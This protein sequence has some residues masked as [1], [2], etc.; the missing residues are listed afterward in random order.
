MTAGTA[1]RR[2]NMTTWAVVGV[3][4]AALAGGLWYV[5]AMRGGGSGSATGEI[6][7]VVKQDFEITTTASGELEARN[8]VELRSGL[9][10]QSLITFIVP[11][12]TRVKAGD[13]VVQLQTD[14][15][16]TELDEV[17]AQV[18]SA[19]AQLV[20]ANKA[21]EIQQNENESKL[22]QAKLAVTIAELTLA[23]WFEGD[24]AIKRR[25][26]S[27]A[28]ERAEVELERLADR[29]GKSQ[30]L[31]ERE[32]V[33]K[34]EM[35]RDEV[36]YIEAISQWKVS[37][38]ERVVYETYQYPKDEKQKRSDVTEAQAEVERVLLNNSSELERKAADRANAEQTLALRESRQARLK[39]Q[40][41]SATIVAPQDGLVVYATSLERGGWGG[42]GDVTLQIGQQVSPNQ[43]MV[44][45]PD[46]SEMLA[47]VRVPEALAGRVRKGMPANVRVDAAGGLMFSGEVESIGVIAETGGWRDPNLREYTVRISLDIGANAE[48]LKPSMRAE[49]KVTLGQAKDA[50]TV[51]IQAVF[52]DGAVQYVNRVAA[53]G[54]AERVPIKLGKRSDSRAEILAGVAVGEHVLLRDPKPTEVAFKGWDTAQLTSMGYV[55]D[56]TGQP[57]A[58]GGSG[59]GGPG[60]PGG[61]GM[62]RGERPAGGGEGVPG[63]GPGAAPGGAPRERPQRDG[64]GSGRAPRPVGEGETKPTTPPAVQPTK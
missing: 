51:P 58:P 26:L 41:A 39:H 37:Q 38:L 29:Y 6:A 47:A 8:R 45:L 35:D 19:R 20:S 62:P 22:R 12:G 18:V 5:V 40:F 61:G 1:I 59:P 50:L 31:Y 27:L 13:L 24:V 64:N 10:R 23:Q 52:Q 60:G 14:Q 33:S 7:A 15:L 17:E 43:L 42:R 63:G 28:V 54:K 11:E 32:F 30:D 21:Y 57:R 9:E 16:K 34:D 49:A 56:E 55:M 36:S 2:G 53:N 48:R 3:G 46:T 4:A 25:D 44:I